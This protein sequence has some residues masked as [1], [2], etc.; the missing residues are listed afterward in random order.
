MAQTPT[1]NNNITNPNT[2]TTTTT[3][4][5]ILMG[6]SGEFVPE[7]ITSALNT[8]SWQSTNKIE[9]MPFEENLLEHIPDITKIDNQPLSFEMNNP[10]LDSQSLQF[11]LIAQELYNLKNEYNKMVLLNNQLLEAK[12]GSLFVCLFVC[13]ASF[14]CLES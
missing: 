5:A 13:F 9:S 3:N 8:D 2:I 14:L 11:H 1:A 4:P 7:L 12:Y 10:P 6:D